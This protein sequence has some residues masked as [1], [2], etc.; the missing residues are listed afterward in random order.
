MRQKKRIVAFSL[1]FI[2][3]TAVLT[4]NFEQTVQGSESLISYD[5]YKADYYRDYSIYEYI[6]S[7]DFTLYYRTVV[8]KNR[9]SA[10]Y[11]GLVTAWEL[12]TFELSDV[13][14]FSKK[15]VGYYETFLFD[16]IY[17]GLEPQNITN[18]LNESVK[19]TAAFS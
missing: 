18:T 16:I 8:E 4:G 12:A 7:D 13:A 6:M 19:S 17:N 2:M 9:S 3:L 11:L 14:E 15:R 5:Q 10:V 1:L